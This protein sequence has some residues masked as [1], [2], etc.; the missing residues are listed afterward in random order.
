LSSAEGLLGHAQGLRLGGHG[1][2][3]IRERFS[4]GSLDT[5]RTRETE[6]TQQAPPQAIP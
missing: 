6:E 3:R 1:A 4:A 2:V 5:A